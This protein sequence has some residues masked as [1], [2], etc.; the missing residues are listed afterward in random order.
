MLILHT[1]PGFEDQAIIVL[2]KDGRKDSIPE[3]QSLSP[4]FD[5]KPRRFV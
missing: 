5:D 4:A 3:Y 1:I 2:P